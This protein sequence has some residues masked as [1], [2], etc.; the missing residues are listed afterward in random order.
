MTAGRTIDVRLYKVLLVDDEVLLC[1]AILRLMRDDSRFEFHV[2][3]SPRHAAQMFADH[4]PFDVLLTDLRFPHAEDGGE[5]LASALSQASPDLKVVFMSGDIPD[6]FAGRG[7]ALD[8]PFERDELVH[9]LEAA[10]G[11]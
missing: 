6:S 8:K 3:T 10:L 4:G 2:V 9:I 11:L 1:R 7:L 5:Q